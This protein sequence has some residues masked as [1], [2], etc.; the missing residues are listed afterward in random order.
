MRNY[1]KATIEQPNNLRNLLNSSSICQ[2]GGHILYT[3]TDQE[4]YIENVIEF[5]VDGI[6]KCETVLFIDT[7]ERFNQLK[8]K[9]YTMNFSEADLNSIIF[10]E[11]NRFYLTDESFNVDYTID[12]LHQHL[13]SLLSNGLK[14]RIWGHV[15]FPDS[16]ANL[17]HLR[18]Y[19]SRSDIFLHHHQLLCIC[20]YD[21]LTVPSTI[22]NEM[23]KVHSYMMTDFEVV[24]SPFY[25][26]NHLERKSENSR[27]LM[28]GI[29]DHRLISVQN[30]RLNQ[31][32]EFYKSLLCEIPIGVIISKN[33]RIVFMN[34]EGKHSLRFSNN[35]DLLEQQL[36]PFLTGIE[37]ENSE[38]NIREFNLITNTGDTLTLQMKSIPTW[39]LGGEATLHTLLDFTE[40]KIKEQQLIRSEKLNIAGELATSIA[41]E[42]RNP[43]T[44][45][46]GF[47]HLI[48]NN[49]SKESYFKIVE[50]EIDKI[51][52][53][54]SEFLML[55]KP[56]RENSKP[57]HIHKILKNVQTWLQQDALSK[58]IDMI[59]INNSEEDLCIEGE[60][61]KI[62][63]VFINL[64]KNAIES[65]DKGKIYI[66]LEKIQDQIKIDIIDEGPGMPKRLLSRIGEPF[67]STK[68]KGTGLG[69]M[70][71]YKIINNHKGTIKVN[72]Q[73]GR[74]T[75]FTVTL[76]LIKSY[77]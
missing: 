69:L 21:G 38:V 70:V 35:L 34:E 30:E 59:V 65:M 24:H 45:I 53:V 49:P 15:V 66:Q 26:T 44:S 17:S 61:I 76:P 71:S 50:D 28:E 6:T 68:E 13:N 7:V 75:T 42:V 40:K 33:G 18:E 25:Q 5:V 11:A 14:V 4:Q 62:K 3:Y 12:R 74:G 51:E 67:Y 36:S 22:Q 41:H 37:P 1:Q 52:Q 8:H 60:E 16:H 31:N 20:A 77:E 55:S 54:S 27:F 9:L 19:E 32:E 10:M 47:I 56:Y 58:H 64:V 23:L 46:K 2:H 48:K 63:Q 43:L 29:V 72:S 57:I 73:V 39:Y